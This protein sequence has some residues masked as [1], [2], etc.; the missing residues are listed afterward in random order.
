MI[1]P[2]SLFNKGL[3]V[4]SWNFGDRIKIDSYKSKKIS[5]IFIDNKSSMLSKYLTPIIC[6]QDDN[7]LWVVGYRKK[8]N[9]IKDDSAYVMVSYVKEY[10]YE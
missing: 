9:N 1:F 7:V 8:N 10:L 4:R 5:D 3:F 2:I 6:D